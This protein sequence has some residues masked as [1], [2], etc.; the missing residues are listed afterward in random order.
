MSMDGSY[1]GAQVMS[2]E[3]QIQAS[4]DLTFETR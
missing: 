1:A 3:L 4:V 2:G